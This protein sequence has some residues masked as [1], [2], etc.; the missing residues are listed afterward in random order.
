MWVSEDPTAIVPFVGE[1][2]TFLVLRSHPGS[3]AKS[4]AACVNRLPMR[5]PS[6][7][8]AVIPKCKRLHG[9]L[10][11]SGAELLRDWARAKHLVREAL[12]QAPA[13]PAEFEPTAEGICGGDCKSRVIRRD[14]IP[15]FFKPLEDHVSTRGQ[16]Q[17]MSLC[18][19]RGQSM[20]QRSVSAS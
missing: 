20:T 14:S 7:C 4:S 17:L 11:R 13:F 10:K 15:N 9:S 18:T 5:L 3:D 19:L 12:R 8:Q 2:H 6:P 1:L 16:S